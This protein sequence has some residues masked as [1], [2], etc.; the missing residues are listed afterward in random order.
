MNASMSVEKKNALRL[1]TE[2][3]AVIGLGM[4]EPVVPFRWDLPIFLTERRGVG[5]FVPL[6]GNGRL[7]EDFTQPWL[8]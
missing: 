5:T 6:Y 1:E 3:S 8:V 2:G 7:S 4:I